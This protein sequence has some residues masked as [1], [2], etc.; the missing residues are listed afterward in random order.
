MLSTLKFLVVGPSEEGSVGVEAKREK[1]T[2]TTAPGYNVINLVI[3]RTSRKLLLVSKDTCLASMR[4]RRR[5]CY[6]CS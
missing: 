3:V 1:L 2:C 5:A 6:I 4:Y